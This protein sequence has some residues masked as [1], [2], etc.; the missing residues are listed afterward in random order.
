MARSILF[1]TANMPPEI[2]AELFEFTV[3]PRHVMGDFRW[4][5]LR[6]RSQA[7]EDPTEGPV[8]EFETGFA[9]ASV[10]ELGQYYRE[11]Y[12]IEFPEH[13]CTWDEYSFA[14]LDERSVKDK[15]MLMVVWYEAPDFD[16]L[17]ED[18]EELR[19]A[20]MPT[21]WKT[22]RLRFIDAPSVAQ[23]ISI[24]AVLLLEELAGPENFREDGTFILPE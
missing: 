12:E 9:G 4:S 3:N 24:N 11:R 17:P 18:D 16:E 10:E 20:W 13:P 6:T 5:L 1:C 14:I 2:F 22:L 15:T 21:G 19:Q 23:S 7:I 8:A